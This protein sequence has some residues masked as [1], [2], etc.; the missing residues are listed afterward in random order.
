MRSCGRRRLRAV[1]TIRTLLAAQA[2]RMLKDPRARRLAT[3]FGCAWLHLYDFNELNE[4]SERHFPTFTEMRSPMFEEAVHYLADLFQNDGSILALFD[5]DY[6]FLNQP[7]A[8]Y[9]GIPGVD[10]PGWRRVGGVKKFGRGGVLG[11]GAT[12]AKQSGASNQ[13]DS[14]RQLGRRG[15][16]GRQAA[17]SA[18]RCAALA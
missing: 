14:P 8:K 11:L 12:L 5:S 4:K 3:E 7:L 9:Y 15:A 18:Q 13:P 6:T 16:P 10:G 17:S 2:V 1:C